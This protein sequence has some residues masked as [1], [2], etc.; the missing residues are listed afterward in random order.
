MNVIY[1]IGDGMALPQVYGAVLASHEELTI[2]Q[3]PYVGVVDTRSSSNTITDSSAGG[4]ALASDHRTKNGMVGMSPDTI[5]VL[6]VLEALK[7][8]GKETGIVVSCYVTHATPAV[9]Y[10]KVPKR[11]HY[12][13]IAMQLAETDN[14]NLIIGGGR[15]HFTQRKDSLNLVEKMVNEYGWTVYDTLANI[16]VTCKKYAVLADDDHMP[17]A[18]ERGDFLPRATN[19]LRLPCQR[20]RLDDG[21]N[22]GFRLCRE[23]G[24]GLC[25]REGQHAR[26]GH[27]RP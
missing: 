26:R 11:S 18:A 19:R 22:V 12:E 9:F 25:Q 7:A 13:D 27:R 4:T 6:T 14:V 5:P 17:K 10:A 23:S 21:R 20:L 8:Q 2:P 16:D 15:K 24:V 1:L 3:F